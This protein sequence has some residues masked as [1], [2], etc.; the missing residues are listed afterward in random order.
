MSDLEIQ[1]PVQSVSGEAAETPGLSQW[2]RISY[3]V[4]AP[5][6]TFIDIKR[7]NRSWWLPLIIMAVVGYIFLAAITYK[8]G[9]PQVV[10][11]MIHLNPKLEDQLSKL[12]PDQVATQKKFMMYPMV[13]AFIAN[14]VITLIAVALGSLGLWGTINFVFAGKATY[15]SIFAV[16]FYA[17]LPSLIKSLLGTLV[18]FAGSDP[19]TFN[20]NNFA[21][22]N[23]AAFL[24][25]NPL[26]ANKAL[27][28][29]TSWLD[30]TTIWTLVLLGIGTAI[31]AGVKR[32]S[33]YL[34]VFGWW[35]IFLVI[36][37]GYAATTS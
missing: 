28:V 4:S 10:N 30:V 36:S 33:G 15:K 11:N 31:V 12:T 3:T 16:W 25:P 32:S 27:Y 34:A 6:K 2:Q 9:W 24:F 7:G 14:P 18:I 37:V 20:I 8:V 17:S 1:S 35:V 13:G 21:P 26:E 22:T 5:S 29:L 19:E 23:L